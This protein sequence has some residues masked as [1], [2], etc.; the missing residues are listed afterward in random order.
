MDIMT[1]AV[2]GVSIVGIITG[3]V[4]VAREAGLPS[5][6]A[7][8]L[9]VFLGIVIGV[10]AATYASSA[11]YIGALGGIAAGLLSCGLYDIGKVGT[12]TTTTDTTTSD[13]TTTTV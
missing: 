9:S 6:Y 5:K 4:R 13:T 1:Y 7:S 11:L 10:S 2:G 3:L 8:A 12:T